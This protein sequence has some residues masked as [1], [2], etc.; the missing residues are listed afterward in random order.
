MKQRY[1][2]LTLATLDEHM[3]LVEGGEFNMGDNGYFDRMPIHRV[4]VCD[5]LLCRY[6]VTQELWAEIMGRNPSPSD[7][8][9]G[10]LPVVQI[11]WLDCQHFISRL[12][13]HTQS[14]YRLPTEAEWEYAARGGRYGHGSKYAGGCRLEEVGWDGNSLWGYLQPV[15]RKRPNELGIYEMNGLPQEWCLDL[16]HESYSSGKG[17]PIDGSAWIDGNFSRVRVARGSYHNIADR[18]GHLDGDRKTIIGLRLARQIG[19]VSQ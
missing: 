1:K 16:W 2:P 8:L 12:N 19:T 14:D 4:K 15:G 9:G 17:A 10:Q 18:D 13:V 3:V 11:S 6:P 7:R 5:F